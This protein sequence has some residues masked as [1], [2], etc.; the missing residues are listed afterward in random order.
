MSTLATTIVNA[1]ILLSTIY[2]TILWFKVIC[3]IHNAHTKVCWIQKADL[4]SNKLGMQES[5][6]D[7]VILL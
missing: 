5:E 3:L 4:L 7:H 2:H 6:S 1:F